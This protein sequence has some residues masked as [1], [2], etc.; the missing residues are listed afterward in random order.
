MCCPA[1]ALRHPFAR[2]P[3]QKA[4][5]VARFSWAGVG[6]GGSQMDGTRARFDGTGAWVRRDWR[7]FFDGTSENCIFLGAA[8]P[9]DR[10]K[11]V[12]SR[13]PTG[14]VFSRGLQGIAFFGRRRGL[15]VA[16]KRV[17]WPAGPAPTAAGF[18]WDFRKNAFL[19]AA[20]PPDR[21][22]NVFLGRRFRWD[23]D[24]TSMGLQKIAFLGAG[25]RVL[26]APGG[27]QVAPVFDGTSM[28]L[29]KIA[30]WGAGRRVLGAPGGLQV[31]PVFDGTS[32]GLQKIAFWGA[33]A[34]SRSL[35][36]VFPG[37]SGRL[38]LAPVFDGT[39]G[40][41]H[42]WAPRGLRITAKTCFW[43]A[44][45]DGTS[46]GLQKI[47]FFGRRPACLGGAG[48]GPTGA[49]VRWDFDGTSENCIFGRR[50]ACFGGAGRAPSAAGVRWDFDGTSE[51]CILGRRRG[52]QIAAKRVP[53]PLGRAPTGAG[54]RWD[55]D[56][57]SENRIFGRRW[58]FVGRGGGATLHARLLQTPW[59]LLRTAAPTVLQCTAVGLVQRWAQLPS[60]GQ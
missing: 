28:G 26:G 39:S 25:R 7:R 22:K 57:T 38:R 60:L 29:Q 48:R 12:F 33:G 16:A 13:A 30:F 47:A 18:R 11:N 58:D 1:A 59:E 44:V 27:V 50:P 15:Q 52:L 40:K 14:A 8:R 2:R 54:F 35:Q 49:G 4:G 31:A 10:C 3:P 55:F 51:N 17:P 24:G 9:P 20:R 37:R 43:G 56:G 34:A 36:N 21:C 23:F 19:G 53:W 6:C 46:M 32:M 41:M 5:V 42:F 45:F